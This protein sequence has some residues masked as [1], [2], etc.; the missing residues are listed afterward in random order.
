MLYIRHG[1]P[2]SIFTKSFF[3]KQAQRQFISRTP[4]A[5]STST[6]SGSPLTIPPSPKPRP[7]AS[8]IIVNERNEIL[9][10]HRNP[11]ATAFGGMHVF[12]G[13]NFD[14]KQDSNLAMTAI[15][16]TFEE[17]GLLLVSP[18]SGSSSDLPSEQVLDELRTS[19]HQQKLQFRYFLSSARLEPE[20]QSLLPFTQWV[21]PIGPPK[22]FHTQFY[23]AFL[24]A[25]PSS[26]FSSGSKQER[27][28]KHDGGQEVIEARFVHPRVALDECREGKIRFMPPQFYILSTLADIL[29]G[30]SNTADQRRKVETLSSG[31]FGRMVINPRRHENDENGRWILTF[32]GDETRG[33][34]KDRKHRVLVKM[35]KGLAS[36]IFMIRNFDIFEDIE[37]HLF[38]V[39]PLPAKL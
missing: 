35:E 20:V 12:P 5:M 32:E 26:G 1:R 14:G 37:S 31:S 18:K 11:R 17:S 23:V 33:G 22:R 2:L 7:S 6:F 9:L 27:I 36:E 21:T 29:E 30:P 4:I 39:P 10:V 28:P 19:I 38:T 15:R 3:V 16:E 34:S 25:A 24:P 13:G 8:V